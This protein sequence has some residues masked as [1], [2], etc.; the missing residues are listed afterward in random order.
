MLVSFQCDCPY[1]GCGESYS[2]HS[3]THAQVTLKVMYI[4]TSLHHL[5][6]SSFSIY[7]VVH[8]SM[9]F[10]FSLQAKKHNLTVN[11]TTFRVWCYVC[12]REVFLEQRPVSPVA[13]TQCYKPLEQVS[14]YLLSFLNFLN[15]LADWCMTS[16]HVWWHHC[17]T[18]FN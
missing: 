2:D 17:Q 11:L 13:S 16:F 6:V 18:H 10:P 14:S 5:S 1:V 8:S 4:L 7:S 3:T 9:W 12:E 15:S